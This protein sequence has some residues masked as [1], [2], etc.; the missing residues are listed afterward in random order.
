MLAFILR[1]PISSFIAISIHLIILASFVYA[2]LSQPEVLKISLNVEENTEIK[3]QVKLTEP[4]QTFA[5]DGSLVQKKLAQL[6]QQEE[7]KNLVQKQL[8]QQTEKEKKL[9]AELK[10]KQQTEKKRADAERKKADAEQKRAEIERRKATEAKRLAEI[11][12]QKV[13]AQTKRADAEKIRAEQ[14]KKAAEQADKQRKEA[15]LKVAEAKK[16]REAEEARTQKLQ[17]EI[18][19]RA[20]EKKRL[21]Q[22]ALVAR[23][24]QEQEQEEANLQRRL[25]EAAADKRAKV[26]KNEMKNLREAYI[27]SIAARVKN[28]WR[29][30]ARVSPNAQCEISIVQTRKG[31]IVSVKVLNCN[32]DASE[33]FKKDAVNAVY[34]SAPLP[35]P[36]IEELFERH[37]QFIFKP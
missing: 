12:K 34:R 7:A 31:E 35:E 1:Y 24:Q 27:S 22:Q 30:A 36:P 16:Q 33:Q 5:V 15:D 10:I 11:E 6:K 28:N 4:M 26:K 3:P 21:E 18:K 23:M 13:V 20:E 32:D 8:E 25:A 29:T 14:A 37:I 19:Q 2:S 9:L 17:V